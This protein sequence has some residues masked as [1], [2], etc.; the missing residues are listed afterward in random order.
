MLSAAQSRSRGDCGAVEEFVIVCVARCSGAEKLVAR[1]GMIIWC[2]EK[3][4]EALRNALVPLV[5]VLRKC[6]VGAEKFKQGVLSAEL[7]GAV[8]CAVGAVRCA[9]LRRDMDPLR[10]EVALSRCSGLCLRM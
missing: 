5:R 9:V 1:V 3:C 7:S 4:N 6:V 8:R 10:R 2:V